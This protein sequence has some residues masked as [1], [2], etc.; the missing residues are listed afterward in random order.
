MF[1]PTEPPRGKVGPSRQ[2]R[3]YIGV[4]ARETGT[5]HPRHAADAAPHVSPRD[6]WQGDPGGVDPGAYRL[7]HGVGPQA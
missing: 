5:A 7:E 6:S 4:R 1:N 3:T 2:T